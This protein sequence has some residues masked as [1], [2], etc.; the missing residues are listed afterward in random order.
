MAVFA[1][2]AFSE[3][4]F[5]TQLQ[6]ALTSHIVCVTICYLLFLAPH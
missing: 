6:T 3:P 1:C 2:N 4:H 5:L